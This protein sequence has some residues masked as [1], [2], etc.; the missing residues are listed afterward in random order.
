MKRTVPLIV[1]FTAGLFGCLVQYVPHAAAQDALS[2]AVTWD[3]IIAAFAAFLG[4][5]SLVFAHVRRVERRQAG[6]GYSAVLL[7]GFA[8]MVVAGLYNGGTG[9]FAAEVNAYPDGTP[10]PMTWLFRY[11]LKPASATMFS[12]LAFFMASAAYRTFRARTVSAALLLTAALIVM[13]GRVPVGAWISPALPELTQWLMD[14]P[15][16]AVKRAIFLGT[17]L[18]VIATSLRIVFGVER[19]Y[20]GGD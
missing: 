4:I 17:G 16:A 1:A 8:L 9:P 2:A 20:L 12:I 18:G 5:G 19:A 15:N 7:F 14:V 3:R 10:T 11:V 6:W 13:I